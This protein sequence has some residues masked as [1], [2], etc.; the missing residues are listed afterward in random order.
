MREKW[1]KERTMNENEEGDSS[2]S[3][4]SVPSNTASKE[5]AQSKRVLSG[6]ELQRLLEARSRFQQPSGSPLI[7][8]HK[9]EEEDGEGGSVEGN[10]DA[11]AN[12]ELLLGLPLN[13]EERRQQK[14]TLERRHHSQRAMSG[15]SRNKK[16][17]RFTRSAS[18]ELIRE[19]ARALTNPSAALPLTLSAPSLRKERNHHNHNHN[20]N[21]KANET[22]AGG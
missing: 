9:A 11:G 17:S 15:T 6:I 18:V 8:V 21:K 10:S 4:S 22:A 16:S 3:T 12:N 14:R 13:K 20:N 19:Q 1:L 2:S 7:L 5:G